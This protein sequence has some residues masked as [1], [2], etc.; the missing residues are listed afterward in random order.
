MISIA[1]SRGYKQFSETIGFV[2]ILFTHSL[3]LF[4]FAIYMILYGYLI[5][6]KILQ[7]DPF[8]LS[9]PNLARVLLILKR[10]TLIM[11]ICSICYGF[12][13][14]VMSLKL[15]ALILDKD[16]LVPKLSPT[17]W[18]LFTDILP[19]FLPNL[20]FLYIM[21]ISNI[22]RHDVDQINIPSDHLRS[23]FYQDE[24][25]VISSNRDSVLSSHLLSEPRGSLY[26]ERVG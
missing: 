2:L 24:E 23:W 21:K 4:F 7:G 5:N 8:T 12:R 22:P 6:F 14:S 18:I 15:Y 26:L 9:N 13:I 11:T 3:S 1:H 17:L 10:I 20:S 16:Q 25:A 19:T